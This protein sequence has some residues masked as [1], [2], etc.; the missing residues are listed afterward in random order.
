M[1]K[2]GLNVAKP[3]LPKQQRG[4]PPVKD[5]PEQIPD[6]PNNVLRSVLATPPLRRDRWC[7]MSEKK[8]S[9]PKGD[10]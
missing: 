5:W 3:A 4:R 8:N 7:Y 1:N 6:T 10:E 9:E 2:L